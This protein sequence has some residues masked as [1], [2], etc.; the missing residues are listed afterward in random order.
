[1]RFYHCVS[2]ELKKRDV[3]FLTL[4]TEDRIPAEV[5]VVLTSIKDAFLIDFP[6]I[7]A[8]E[9]CSLAAEKAVRFLRGFKDRHRKITLGIDPGKTPGVAI[10]GDNRAVDA[11]ALSSPE[12]VRDVVNRVIH[13]HSPEEL[14]I[15]L[16]MGGGAYRQ[17][18][19]RA[20]SSMGNLKIELVNEDST[21]IV[22]AK[23]MRDATAALSI[24]LTKG[25]TISG[26][27]PSRSRVKEGEIRNIQREARRLSPGI[28]ISKSLAAKVA[29]GELSLKD[30]AALQKRKK[31]SNQS[32]H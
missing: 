21:S 4:K 30:A 20:L 31:N 25:R 27:F 3:E 1:M 10:L 24:A 14:L 18:I 5:N 13:L 16:G 17:R 32:L 29:K 8:E 2:E 9:D 12:E 6:V 19:L 28:T 26:K 15:R 7:V 23:P 11:F 22:K